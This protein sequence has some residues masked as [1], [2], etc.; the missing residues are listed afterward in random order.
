M[1]NSKR[2]SGQESNTEKIDCATMRGRRAYISQ[3]EVPACVLEDA[4]R[5]PYAI[6]TNY[7]FQPT[8][9]LKR[10]SYGDAA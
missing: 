2:D 8:A 1:A 6:G 7:K 10:R 5:I 9:P 4:L 3:A